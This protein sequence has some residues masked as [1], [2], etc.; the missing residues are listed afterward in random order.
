MEIGP[1]RVQG[2]NLVENEGSWHEFANLLFGE[3]PSRA[4]RRADPLVDQPVGTGFSY[5]NTDSYVHELPEVHCHV[6]EFS[7]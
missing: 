1:F 6:E 5:V 4:G 3:Y 2:D 7:D